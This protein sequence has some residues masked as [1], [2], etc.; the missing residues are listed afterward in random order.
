MHALLLGVYTGAMLYLSRL[1]GPGME[2][3]V[4]LGEGIVAITPSTPKSSAGDVPTGFDTA[5]S[6]Q[7][8]SPSMCVALSMMFVVDGTTCNDRRLC[9]MCSGMTAKKMPCVM[10]H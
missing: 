5:M 4:D 2:V 7:P 8:A 3:A 9:L 6:G 10:Y 1:T